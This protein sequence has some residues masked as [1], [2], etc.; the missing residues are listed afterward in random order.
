MEGQW[1]R[2]EIHTSIMISS[3]QFPSEGMQMQAG[4]EG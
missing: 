1:L 4:G 2:L 3:L